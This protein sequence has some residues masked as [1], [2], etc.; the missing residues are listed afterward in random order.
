MEKGGANRGGIQIEVGQDLAHLDA[1]GDVVLARLALLPLVCP[2]AVGERAAQQI[3]IEA[4]YRLAEGVD[5]VVGQRP[6]VAIAGR[7]SRRVGALDGFC[8]PFRSHESQCSIKVMGG[9]T[10]GDAPLSTPTR[11]AWSRFPA[12]SPPLQQSLESSPFASYGTAASR[13]RRPAVPYRGSWRNGRSPRRHGRGR[14]F[15]AG[16]RRPRAAG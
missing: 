7:R 3:E 10:D 6:P 16:D 5:E 11:E 4:L 1:V 15:P 8:C 2:L 12:G 13:D 9:P 14:G